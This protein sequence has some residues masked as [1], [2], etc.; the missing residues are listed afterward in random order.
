M[1]IEEIYAQ[2]CLP[3]TLQEHMI[4]VAAV[5]QMMIDHRQWPPLDEQ[6]ILRTALLHDLGNIV[7]MDFSLHTQWY[8]QPIEYRI[9][10]KEEVKKKYG[11][12]CHQATLAMCQ[13]IGVDEKVLQ[14]IDHIGIESYI[15][16]HGS[17]ETQIVRY[18]DMRVDPWGIV[19]LD[20]RMQNGHERYKECANRA[21]EPLWS[22]VLQHA[23]EQEK[24]LFCLISCKPEDI[25]ENKTQDIQ[26]R[27]RS[28]VC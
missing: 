11:T 26:Q 21:K 7:K 27:L 1:R 8:G 28:F 15:E 22:L 18:A 2:F 19:S 16:E 14:I 12:T 25:T 20:Q 23:Y 5:A 9:Q 6:L 4:R 24:S 17:R 13:E 3:K 10:I